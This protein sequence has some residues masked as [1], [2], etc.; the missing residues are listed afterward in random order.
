M[1]GSYFNVFENV[2]RIRHADPKHA[3]FWNVFNDFPE[4][5]DNSDSDVLA[6]GARVLTGQPYFNDALCFKF[7][8]K[9]R[10]ES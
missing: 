9:I 1:P 3:A 10:P 7:K 2:R 4:Q 6:I 8:N 5:I